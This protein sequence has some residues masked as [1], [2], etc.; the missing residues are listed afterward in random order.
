MINWKVRV[1]NPHFWVQI[2][3][4]IVVTMLSYA[5]ISGAEITTW[6]KL[7]DLIVATLSNPYCLVLILVAV[8]NAIIDPTTKGLKDSERAL[9]YREPQ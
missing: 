8:Y 3:V 5:G 1:K 7:L 2:V 9:D 4:T 6:G